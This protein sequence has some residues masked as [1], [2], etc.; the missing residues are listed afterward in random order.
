MIKKAVQQNDY[1]VTSAL[2]IFFEDE[3]H[4]GFSHTASDINEEKSQY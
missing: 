4:R 3:L 1:R 2:I